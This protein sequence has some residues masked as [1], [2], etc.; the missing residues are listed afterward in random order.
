M[1]LSSVFSNETKCTYIISE[2]GVNHNG[3]LE[4]ALA[5]IDASHE[6]GVDA[7]KFQKR[8]LPSIYSKKILDD[9]NSAEWTFDYLIPLLKECE[10]SHE[11][12]Q[13]IKEKC[14]TLGLDLVITPF[15]EKSAEFVASLGVVAFKIAS[16]DM[17]NFKLIEKCASYNIPLIIST[18]MWSEEDIK[19]CTQRYN[20]MG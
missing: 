14:E 2:I 13:T 6:A 18:G 11:E 5:L 16:A 7:V 8:D 19:K 3:S 10:L 17:T 1:T 12:Y 9:P 20:K 15:D 4:T